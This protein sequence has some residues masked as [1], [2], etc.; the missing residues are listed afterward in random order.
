MTL[1]ITPTLQALFWVAAALLAYIYIGYPVLLGSLAAIAPRQQK[2]SESAEPTVTLL[3][4]AYN[5][6][7]VIEAKIKNCLSL[8]YPKHLLEVVVISD[9]SDDGTDEIVQRYSAFGVRLVRQNERKGKSA[10]LNLAVPE[11]RGEILVFSDANALYLP[12]AVRQLV[13]PFA[14][15]QVGYVVGNSRYVDKVSAPQAAEAE[16][17]YWKLETW[18]KKKESAFH[19]VV[20][21]DGAIYA[22]R[23]DLYSPLRA[24]DISDF[25]NPL[26]IIDRGYLGVF[27]PR[28]VSYEETAESFPKEFRRKVRIVSRSLNAIR[29]APGVL[30]PFRQ[31]RHCFALVSHKLLRWF[32]PIFMLAMMIAS[33]ALWKS[34][35]VRA[36][37]FLQMIFYGMAIVGWILQRQDKTWRI[38]SFAFYFCLVNVASLVACLKC[39]R[40]DLS[41]TWVPPRQKASSKA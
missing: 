8:D 28:A 35:L 18:L 15:P 13:R 12:D 4:S 2:Q 34:P 38:F 14:D 37:L 29:R 19:S 6:H 1:N 23:R 30:N 9:C 11:T 24:T 33:L 41:G 40:G 22:I 39:L 21:G 26:Q 36:A 20:G 5:E 31:P 7:P 16:G 25:L 32:A 17:L 3:I 10:G 27:E